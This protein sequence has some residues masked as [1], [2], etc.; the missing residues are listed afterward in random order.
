MSP[1]KLATFEE[2]LPKPPMLDAPRVP[3]AA[4]SPPVQD[5]PLLEAGPPGTTVPFTYN[6]NSFDVVL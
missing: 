2:P 1:S 3:S 6:S 5:P 4:P